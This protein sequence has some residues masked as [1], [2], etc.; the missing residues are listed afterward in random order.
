MN[1]N[2]TVRQFV[3]GKEERTV[4][5]T[6]HTLEEFQTDL[7]NREAVLKDVEAHLRKLYERKR[8][9]LQEALGESGS[10]K[11]EPYRV[12]QI[13]T[14]KMEDL[15]DLRNKLLVEQLFLTKLMLHEVS[16]NFASDTSEM[17]GFT[18]AVSDLDADE[19]SSAIDR[20]D[21]KED[22]S[23]QVIEEV[24]KAM[25]RTDDFDMPLGVDEMRRQVEELEAEEI[26][27]DIPESA[28][29]EE[30]DNKIQEELDKL[31]SDHDIEADD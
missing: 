13:M 30:I 9:A 7:D 3:S 27:A 31:E 16:E 12:A 8:D 24:N 1:L 25:D 17:F 28:M 15:N 21:A 26:E 29:D 10:D 23:M 20:A 19:I 22:E 14:M 6:G 4:L 18:I 2:D 11:L 5:G